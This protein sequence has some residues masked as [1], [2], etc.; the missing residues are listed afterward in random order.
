MTVRIVQL[1]T[2]NIDSYGQY[3]LVSVHAYAQKHGYQHLVQRSSMI[4]DMHINWTK[5]ALLQR[6]LSSTTADYLL[7][8]DADTIITRP[9][10]P[11]SFFIENF[12]KPA[13]E[14]MMPG[15]TPLSLRLKKKPNAGFILLKNSDR[16]KAIIDRWLQAAQNE[17]QHLNDIHPRNQRVYWKYVMPQFQ[18]YQVI[19]PKKYF[20]KPLFLLGLPLNNQTQFL[21]HIT[22]SG[23]GKRESLMLSYLQDRS[24]LETIQQ[25]L[26]KR[27]DNFL[28]T[29]Y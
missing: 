20:A 5:M 6:E 19:L 7:L 15:D 4:D 18:D 26:K 10:V 17:G 14:I 13:T 11:V 16:G 23:E 25:Q 21:Y 1:C 3:S 2:P 9:E 12:A 27:E 8:I 29:G 28:P 22:Q 24:A